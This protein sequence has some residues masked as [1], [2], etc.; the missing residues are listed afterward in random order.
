MLNVIY[1][2]YAYLKLFHSD[3]IYMVATGCIVCLFKK[4]KQNKKQGLK[5]LMISIIIIV[6]CFR[7]FKTVFS[8]LHICRCASIIIRISAFPKTEDEID[9]FPLHLHLRMHDGML[10]LWKPEISLLIRDSKFEIQ[11][12]DKPIKSFI[13][14]SVSYT[15]LN[16]DHLYIHIPTNKYNSISYTLAL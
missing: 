1:L 12:R 11:N 16:I 15:G 5:L 8:Y 13:W 3:F 14:E 2:V 10:N 9:I 7:I 6:L 4:Q